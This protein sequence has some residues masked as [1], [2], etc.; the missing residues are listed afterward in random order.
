MVFHF[1]STQYNE[2]KNNFTG[3]F[4]VSRCT[5]CKRWRDSGFFCSVNHLSGGEVNVNHNKGRGCY[6]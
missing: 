4:V 3:K 6:A 1:T 2:G 5:F